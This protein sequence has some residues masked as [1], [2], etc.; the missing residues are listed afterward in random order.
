MRRRLAV[1]LA[2]LAVAAPLAT[3]STSAAPAAKASPRVR[4]V[5][6]VAG[7]TTW[8]TTTFTVEGPAM[9][10]PQPL[11]VFF[12]VD[13]TPWAT[14]ETFTMTRG[15]LVDAALR[16]ASRPGIRIGVGEYRDLGDAD[17]EGPATYRLRRRLAPPDASLYD[18]IAALR[19]APVERSG[20]AA[21]SVALDE[22]VHGNGHLPFVLPGQDAGF[23][24]EA[25]FRNGIV[26]LVTDSRT[27]L[28][29]RDPLSLTFFAE[30]HIYPNPYFTAAYASYVTD[31][32][33]LVPWTATPPAGAVDDAVAMLAGNAVTFGPHPCIGPREK[34]VEEVHVEDRL[35]C[36]PRLD[37][38]DARASRLRVGALVP[39]LLDA[40][41][42]WTR[43]TVRLPKDF[44]NPDGSY[45]YFAYGSARPYAT[46]AGKPFRVTAVIGL[47]CP[48]GTA[49]KTFTIPVGIAREMQTRRSEQKDL[50]TVRLRC[51]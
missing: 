42:A 35:V 19:T 43:G 46:D 37:P 33:A 3:T 34:Q 6:A 23:A 11:D 48:E 21:A 17:A 39:A 50:A 8:T 13:T 31:V 30:D 49:G 32:V 36:A 20:A 41:G 9:P 38:A 27:A 7:D 29:P 25:P 18:T 45:G 10:D 16:L 47:R 24:E 1:C 14:P 15:G 5:T 51:R 40:R 2:L 12:L 4:E 26:V 44:K 22:A 28:T